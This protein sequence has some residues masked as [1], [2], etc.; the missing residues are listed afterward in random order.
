M[1]G[2]KYSDTESLQPKPPSHKRC[3]DPRS[4]SHPSLSLGTTAAAREHSPLC[5]ILPSF[6]FPHDFTQHPPD[7]A[8]CSTPYSPASES[9]PALHRAPQNRRLH[10]HTSVLGR[11]DTTARWE[12]SSPTWW[13]LTNTR[14]LQTSPIH[15][16]F[17]PELLPKSPGRLFA[18]NRTAAGDI[19]PTLRRSGRLPTKSGVVSLLLVVLFSGEENNQCLL[20][21][22]FVTL[23]FLPAAPT[24]GHVIATEQRGRSDAFTQVTHT[25]PSMTNL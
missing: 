18:K 11:W 13:G 4:V 19:F 21:R 6:C 12:Q 7:K 10:G 5:P 23:L 15:Q 22:S 14:Q 24:Q 16:F 2:Q 20:C 3:C 25:R 17:T 1:K 8:D 9:P